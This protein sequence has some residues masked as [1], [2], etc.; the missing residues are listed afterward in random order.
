MTIENSWNECDHYSIPAFSLIN[1]F[2]TFCFIRLHQG[3]HQKKR[4]SSYKVQ[5]KDHPELLIYCEHL[6]RPFVRG[7]GKVFV[8]VSVIVY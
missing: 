4:N 1:K 5:H 7:A 3:G 6:L 2:I 8:S